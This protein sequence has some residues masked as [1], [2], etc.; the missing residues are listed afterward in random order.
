MSAC[1]ICG[2]AGY[3]VDE[4]HGIEYCGRRSCIVNER[5]CTVCDFTGWTLARD[6]VSNEVVS[7]P[8]ERCNGSGYYL[9]DT[10]GIEV[11]W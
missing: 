7:T 4:E 3:D 9:P 1:P 10:V 6:V 2:T 11:S 5:P 8:C